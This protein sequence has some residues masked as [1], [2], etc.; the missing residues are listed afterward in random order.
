MAHLTA[1]TMTAGPAPAIHAGVNTQICRF[2]TGGTSSGSLTVA[3]TPLPAGAE[4]VR[5]EVISSNNG[6]GK[7]SASAQTLVSVHANIGGMT[8]PGSAQ[9]RY[10][11]SAGVGQ[12]LLVAGNA[13][14]F[15]TRITASANLFLRYTNNANTGTSTLDVAVIVQYL[16]RNRGD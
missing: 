16:T 9:Y 13:S 15:G 11:M 7:P 1:D 8:T 12:T 14:S 6:W 10:I 3:L 4:V 5:C 2:A